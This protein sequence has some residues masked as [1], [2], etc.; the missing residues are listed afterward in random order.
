[1]IDAKLLTAIITGSTSLRVLDVGQNNIGDAGM[2]LILEGLQHSKS[3][4]KLRVDQ[5][6]LSTKG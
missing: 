4:S 2:A 5:C 6:R 3:L 1:M